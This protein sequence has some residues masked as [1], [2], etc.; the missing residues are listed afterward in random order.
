[1]ADDTNKDIKQFQAPDMADLLEY[2]EARSRA[3]DE[4]GQLVLDAS[5]LQFMSLIKFNGI[6]I[7]PPVLTQGRREEMMSYKHEALRR[8]KCTRAKKKEELH[9]KVQSIVAGVESTYS[10]KSRSQ[11]PRTNGM[12][13]LLE[14]RAAKQ[15]SKSLKS[16]KSPSPA[17]RKSSDKYSSEVISKVTT[18]VTSPADVKVPSEIVINVTNSGK[19]TSAPQSKTSSKSPSKSSSAT[20]TKHSMSP[21]RS[22]SQGSGDTK[23]KEHTNYKSLG[24][25]GSLSKQKSFSS[26]HLDRS[27]TQAGKFDSDTSSNSAKNLSLSPNSRALLP[28]PP[29]GRPPSRGSSMRQ[30]SS[31]PDLRNIDVAVKTEDLKKPIPSRRSLSPKGGRPQAPERDI[32]VKT[33]NNNKNTKLKEKESLKKDKSQENKPK[34][35]SSNKRKQIVSENKTKQNETDLKKSAESSTKR[36]VDSAAKDMKVRSSAKSQQQNYALQ[37]PLEVLEQ[38]LSKEEEF[39]MNKRFAKPNVQGA[40]GEVRQELD[41]IQTATAELFPFPISEEQALATLDSLQSDFASLEQFD[42]L[43]Q[44][45]NGIP[46][47][48]LKQQ[49]IIHMLTKLSRA[50]NMEDTLTSTT[51]SNAPGEPVRQGAKVESSSDNRSVPDG[52][53]GR[54]YSYSGQTDLSDIVH[55]SSVSV[56]SENNTT[57]SS[58]QNSSAHSRARMSPTGSSILSSASSVSASRSRMSPKSLK[59]TVHFS[60]LVTEISTSASQSYEDKISYRKLDITPKTSENF[61]DSVDG[62]MESK[63]FHSEG[64]GQGPGPSLSM[65][66]SGSNM[67]S[68]VALSPSVDS[69][70]SP[71][72]FQSH[73]P[74]ENSSQ[75]SDLN[76]SDKENEFVPADPESSDENY[77]GDANVRSGRNQPVLNV[78]TVNIPAGPIGDNHP[79][80]V[81]VKSSVKSDMSS[82]STLK[83]GQE[84]ILQENFSKTNLNLDSQYHYGTSTADLDRYIQGKVTPDESISSMQEEIT[85]AYLLS[86]SKPDRD[87]Y[88]VDENCEF[89]KPKKIAKKR[90]EVDDSPVFLKPVIFS[91]TGNSLQ[92]NRSMLD[93]EDIIRSNLQKVQLEDTDSETEQVAENS[94][95]EWESV[96]DEEVELVR[97]VPEL[98]VMEEDHKYGQQKNLETVNVFEEIDQPLECEEDSEDE[99]PKYG[100]ELALTHND[101]EEQLT[102]EEETEQIRTDEENDH[103]NLFQNNMKI[104]VEHQ[105]GTEQPT[106]IQENIEQPLSIQRDNDQP[107]RIQEYTEQPVRIQEDTEQTIRI[108]E[109]TEQ[110]V[111]IQEVNDRPIRIQEDTDQPVRIQEDTNRSIRS[112]DIERE[113]EA[114]AEHIQKYLNQVHEQSLHHEENDAN[115]DDISARNSQTFPNVMD[116]IGA[117]I[118]SFTSSI[119]NMNHLSQEELFRLQANQFELIQQK[120]I[121][122]QRAQLEEL[123]VAQRKEQMS[124][125]HEI[126]AY[127]QQ[128]KS[129]DTDDNISLPDP[130]KPQMS[131]SGPQVTQAWQSHQHLQQHLPVHSSAKS[132]PFPVRPVAYTGPYQNTNMSFNTSYSTIAPYPDPSTVGPY[133][134]PRMCMVS[135]ID[136]RAGVS[137]NIPVGYIPDPNMSSIS[138][139]TSYSTIPHRDPGMQR[140]NPASTQPLG[141][142]HS[143]D[144][145]SSQTSNP[146]IYPSSPSLYI[147]P[148]DRDNVSEVS[149]FAKATPKQLVFSN[150]ST[151]VRVTKTYK[152]IQHSPVK[153]MSSQRQDSGGYVIPDKVFDPA[154]QPKFARVSAAVKGYLTRRLLRTPKVQ[155]IVKKLSDTRNFAF[156][157]QAETPIKKGTFSREDRI[158]LERIV[159]QLQANL[160]DIHDVFFEIPISERMAIISAA[161]QQEQDRRMRQS[162]RYSMDTVSRSQPKLSKATLKAMER[163]KKAQLAEESVFGSV[164]FRPKSAPPATSSPHPSTDI[165]DPLRR[166]YHSLFVRALRPIQGQISPITADHQVT[167]REMKERPRTA[168]EKRKST[169][170]GNKTKKTGSKSGKSSTNTT[171]NKQKTAPATTKTKKMEK[172]W[173]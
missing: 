142:I 160:L 172:A 48:S 37:N 103:V 105:A 167:V 122:H 131:R 72:E 87:I 12:Y 13:K 25:L 125:E 137:M 154:M 1:M 53:S 143:Q 36:N 24:K 39:E 69:S 135:S 132:P 109:D 159:A 127:Q 110:E 56:T 116:D 90:P 84:K 141:V 106:R 55:D 65:P 118:Q 93:E 150:Q 30:S 98:N 49:Q 156:N 95:E 155:E 126:E 113:E 15:A 79:A 121:E 74:F 162:E 151:P 17:S 68:N 75:D 57:N 40:V 45:Y 101:A 112:Q 10:L 119:Q 23:K 46:L 71:G 28:H 82:G 97:D 173:R 81:H 64:Q 164:E 67:L 148:K 52:A 115:E 9:A 19:E 157:F 104:S 140:G 63:N 26:Q 161:R 114:K 170:T 7:L 83:E 124:L 51:N 33:D 86:H 171:S 145:S 60:T 18:K 80:V 158:L 61:E 21:S 134:D 6:S 3:L 50:L 96:K 59:N 77:S 62:H 27:G 111:K 20:A 14:R 34:S 108:Q 44:D 85:R 147:N 130:L 73:N 133:Q 70:G 169:E 138:H 8:E 38:E 92:E 91:N 149:G 152:P 153:Q 66:S 42:S 166:H 107:S 117:L 29:V 165:S 54:S 120:L 16:S 32:S 129:V 35:E 58:F 100:K 43:P 168:P 136:P 144:P 102:D 78:Y 88:Q 2:F 128:I 89:K 123:F 5:T 22:T 76:T 4:E 47:T 146:F 99:V 94:E 41:P 31:T 11:L 163:K 139:N